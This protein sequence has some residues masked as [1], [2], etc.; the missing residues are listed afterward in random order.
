MRKIYQNKA[1][2]DLVGVHLLPLWDHKA[3]QALTDPKD[4]KGGQSLNPVVA[5]EPF[6]FRQRRLGNVGPDHAMLLFKEALRDNQAYFELVGTSPWLV[7]FP[8]AWYPPKKGDPIDNLSTGETYTIAEIYDGEVRNVLLGGKRPPRAGDRLRFRTENELQ[9]NHAFPRVFAKGMKY[10]T[11]GSV[12]DAPEPWA[13]TI[14]F[15]VTNSQPGTM[16]NSPPF[17]GKSQMKPKFMESWQDEEDP[18]MQLHTEGWMFDNLVQFDCWAKTNATAVRLLNWF[19]D[20]MFRHSWIFEKY[21]VQKLLY[22]KRDEDVETPV[23]R[24]D[25][26]KRTVIYYMRTEKIFAFR[27]RRLSQLKLYVS[28]DNEDGELPEEYTDEI[29][30]PS[31]SVSLEWPDPSSSVSVE[32]S[33]L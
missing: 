10:T 23:W 8:Y 6:A 9:F 27:T 7:C 15:I 5:S 1:L 2:Y 33:E 13:D 29:P 11:F 12:A 16:D 25:I 3:L 26:T 31:S 18:V 14:T 24:N 22:W 28:V 20:F 21:G 30:E 19:E 32:I 4:A 17:S